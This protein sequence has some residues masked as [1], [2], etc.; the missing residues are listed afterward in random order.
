MMTSCFWKVLLHSVQALR[1]HQRVRCVPEVP[2]EQEGEVQVLGPLCFV[3]LMHSL[4]LQQN[5]CELTGGPG[6]PGGP[7]APIIP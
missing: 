3:G 6:G 7:L 1:A 4:C 5:V 2:V